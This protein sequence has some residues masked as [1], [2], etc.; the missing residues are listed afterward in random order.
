MLNKLKQKLLSN[1]IFETMEHDVN[2]D[3]LMLDFMSN[4]KSKQTIRVP[5]PDYGVRD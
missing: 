3:S 4:Q 5:N 1:F 2:S